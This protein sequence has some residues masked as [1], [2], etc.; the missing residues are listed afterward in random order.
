MK[1]VQES[2][3]IKQKDHEI[4]FTILIVLLWCNSILLDYVRGAML[5]IPILSF[6]A[7]LVIPIVI[8]AMFLLSMKSIASRLCSTDLLFIM[9][10]LV[11]Y[12]AHW[13][14]YPGNSYYYEGNMW[15]FLLGRL[16]LYFVG[17]AFCSEKQEERLTILYKASVA[18][19]YCFAVYHLVRQPLDNFT[20]GTGDM[21]SSYNLLPHACLVFYRMMQKPNGWNISAFTLSA[22]LLFL[23]GSRGPVLCIVIFAAV[24]L[25]MGK[26]IKRPVMFLI[27]AFVALLAIFIEDFLYIVLGWA[28]DLA[29]TFGLSTRVFDKYLSG[30]FAVSDTRIQIRN[31]VMHYL[32]EN[33]IFGLGIYGDRRVAGG[34][35]AHNIL[36]EILGQYGYVLGSIALITIAVY[37][38]RA[39]L[40]SRS[41]GDAVGVLVLMLLMGCNL[42][43]M[44]S[45]SYLAEPFFFFLIGYCTAQLRRKKEADRKEIHKSAL[46]KVRK[47][48]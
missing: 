38:I 30:D 20:L 29:E 14:I 35:Y 27:I 23:L 40:F 37:V 6:T 7:D 12:F 22:L 1:L 15:S 47:H 34:H 24:V 39:Y 36:I 44:V 19:I 21:N 10:M 4:Y 43:L 45:G 18:T 41:S 32:N 17:V 26:N 3:L 33:P 8:G 13:A 2:K 9:G 48:I 16:P 42:K 11:V 5:K 28:Y 46:L 31:A 25:F